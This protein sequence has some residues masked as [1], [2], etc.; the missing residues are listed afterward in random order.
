M[1]FKRLLLIFETQMYES[2]SL[3]QY[4]WKDAIALYN[5]QI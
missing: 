4:F 5:K 1:S 2:S 3:I